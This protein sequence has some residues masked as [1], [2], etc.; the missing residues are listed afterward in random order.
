MRMWSGLVG[1]KHWP[2]GTQV[3][4]G[5]IQVL[6]VGRGEVISDT[7]AGAIQMKFQERVAVVTAAFSDVEA[8]I[9]SGCIDVSILV[10]GDAGIPRTSFLGEFFVAVPARGVSVGSDAGDAPAFFDN[11]ALDGTQAAGTL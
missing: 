6:F 7:K 5:T 8:S 9:S 3:A 4:V 10:G 11:S 1:K 2:T